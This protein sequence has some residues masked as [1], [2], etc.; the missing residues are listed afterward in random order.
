MS[1]VYAICGATLIDGNG[2]EPILNSTVVI[3]GNKIKSVGTDIPIPAESTVIDGTGKTL[4]PGLI[5]AHT[6][7]CMGDYDLVIPGK[8]GIILGFEDALAMR[9][10]KSFS[11]ATRT[12]HAGFTTIRDAGDLYENTIQLKKAIDMGIVTGPR[13]VSC[14]QF[15]G[16]T[17][18]HADY[19]SYWQKRTDSVTNVCNGKE[20]TLLAVRRQIKA[21]ADWIKFFAT[22]GISD[23]YDKQEFNDE[24]IATIVNE[25]HAKQKKVFAHCM[26][27]KGTLAAVKGGIDSVEH[28]SRMTDEIFDEM[29]ARGTWYVPTLC[30]L[31]ASAN[32]GASFGIPQWYSE[33]AQWFYDSNLEGVKEARERGIKIAFGSDSGFNAQKHGM[34]SREFVQYVKAGFSPMEAI[35]CATHNNAEMLGLLDQIGTIEEGKLADLIL[36]DGDP[37]ADISILQDVDRITTVMRDGMICKQI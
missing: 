7:L 16:A 28:G 21:G 22:G 20:E 29:A 32:L 8:S 30:V 14:N 12:L 34:N 35:V 3:S 9:T 1:N 17:G 6:H 10:M 25:A 4:M 27:E 33:R 11:Y 2:G 13:I 5:D 26:W 19:Y 37:L 36:V 23:P 15:L 24:E 18:G 31:D